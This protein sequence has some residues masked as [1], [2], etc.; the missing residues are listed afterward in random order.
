MGDGFVA[1]FQGGFGV[2][3]GNYGSVTEDTDSHIVGSRGHSGVIEN[4]KLH[5]AHLGGRNVGEFDLSRSLGFCL[6]LAVRRYPNPVIC[7]QLLECCRIVILLS[8]NP[9]LFNVLQGLR[10]NG[11]GIRL[12]LLGLYGHG[13]GEKQA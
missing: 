5:V 8:T 7:H 10:G 1:I 3:S 9:R 2:G 11:V 6:A 13:N 12:G 4:P